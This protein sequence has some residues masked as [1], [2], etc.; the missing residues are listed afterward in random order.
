MTPRQ[1]HALDLWEATGEERATLEHFVDYLQ[2]RHAVELGAPLD[3]ILDA[4]L[5]IDRAALEEA[6]EALRLA[7]A[8]VTKA[9]QVGPALEHGGALDYHDGKPLGE[10]AW[11]EEDEP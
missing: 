6:R 3:G 10:G 8:A 7:Q 4:Y 11:S 2:R 1:R 5:G 9:L